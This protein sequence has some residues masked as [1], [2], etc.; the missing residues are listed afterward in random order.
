MVKIFGLASFVAFIAV[1]YFVEA[2]FFVP[3]GKIKTYFFSVT[4]TVTVFVICVAA[5]ILVSMLE[6]KKARREAKKRQAEE[7]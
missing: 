5:F 3:E 4:F 7:A 1:I 2:I 6:K